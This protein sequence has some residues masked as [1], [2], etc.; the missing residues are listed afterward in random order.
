MSL[1][2]NNCGISLNPADLATRGITVKTLVD[3]DWLNG[4][5]FLRQNSP[6]MVPDVE[7]NM[8]I[9][10]NDPEVRSTVNVRA[11]DAVPAHRLGSKRFE[12]FSE[13]SSLR[14]AMAHLILKAQQCKTEFNSRVTYESQEKDENGNP[15]VPPLD[16]TSQATALIIRTV[17]NEVFA[18]EISVLAK[19][20]RGESR[21]SIRE[22]RKV[23]KMSN[24]YRL[25]PFL[26]QEGILC[27]GGRLHRADLSYE[28][29][30]PIILPKEHHI[31]KLLI[32]QYHQNV[33][34]KVV[35]SHVV[36]YGEPD[37]GSSVVID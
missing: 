31:T 37:I 36:P 6:P 30:H 24:I 14:R 18:T 29:R 8:D 7:H 5:S 2:P 10:E 3:S 1:N 17:Q 21:E 23:L 12:R 26:D 32:R 33:N 4:P 22:R 16:A 19:K 27:V 34:I 28:E 20:D 35:S 25:D 15:D 9:D 13:W 11:T